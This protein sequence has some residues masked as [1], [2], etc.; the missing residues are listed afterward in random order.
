MVTKYLN[1]VIVELIKRAAEHDNSKLEAPEVEYFDEWT[2]KLGTVTY[3]SEEYKHFLKELQPA[4]D[5][6]YAVNRHHPQHFPKG[7][8]GMNLVDL[9]EMLCD[10]KA[11]TMRQSGGNLLKSIHINATP[12]KFNY[13]QELSQIFE[14]TAEFFEE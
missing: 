14:N 11:S 3:N 1:L 8:Q 2:P 10:W 7:V 4:L 5:H 13:S 6:H 12:D 9:I